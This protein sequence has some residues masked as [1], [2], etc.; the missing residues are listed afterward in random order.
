MPWLGVW[1]PLAIVIVIFTVSV[2]REPR[3]LRPGLY[4]LVAVQLAVL[5]ALGDI[6]D[7]A[8][9][10][11]DDLT[12][13]WILLG[14]LLLGVVTVSLLGLFLVAN[15][16]TMLRREGRGAATLVSLA[17]GLVV[18]GYVALAIIAVTGTAP[19]AIAWTFFLGMPMMYLGWVFSGFLLYS[20]VYL[21]WN[22][23]WGGPIDAVVV[24]GAGLRRG[25]EVTPL[26]ASRLDQARAVADRSRAAGRDPV[27]VVSGGQGPD[28]RIS[29]ADAMARYLRDHGVPADRLLREDRST[30]TEENLAFSA[31]VLADQ[32]PRRVAVVT[33][34]Y[35]AFR[36]ATLMRQAGLPGYS[37]GSPTARY[38]WP[39]A[40]VREYLALLRDHRWVN[41]IVLGL[42]SLP[43]LWS[44][45][46][47]VVDLLR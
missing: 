31:R 28:E 33:N 14:L 43:M 45:G 27:I 44:I 34:N 26:L 24:L 16:V 15:A 21:W 5:A 46:Y 37:V 6:L 32:A 22:K 25:E 11:G 42:L 19:R 1:T 35:H 4:L 3:R 39:S 23:R 7:L 17:L 10:W 9:R 2:V 13:A 20:L 41:G 12:A 30:T 8:S 40:T 47:G 29:E 18:V 36:A 38:F